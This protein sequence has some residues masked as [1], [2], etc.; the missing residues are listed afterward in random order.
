M[1]LVR[2]HRDRQYSV[3]DRRDS[4]RQ[5]GQHP[6]AGGEAAV[7]R[8]REDHRRQHSQRRR[9]HHRA[10]A[11]ERGHHRGDGRTTETRASKSAAYSRLTC[12]EQRV[13]RRAM[14]SP[15]Q[16]KGADRIM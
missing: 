14:A 1:N 13:N 8:G 7:A 3:C 5:A 16:K 9:D 11:A 6:R 4:K 12:A 10:R 2:C 15:E